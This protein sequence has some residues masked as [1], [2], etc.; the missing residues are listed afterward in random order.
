VVAA[1]VDT[2]VLIDILR[3]N[4]AA[5]NWLTQQPDRL[6]IV[7]VVWLEVIQ[8]ADNRRKQKEA[9]TLL[10]RFERVELIDSDYD[11]AIKQA[12]L[13]NL[14]HNVGGVDCLIASVN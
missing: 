14:S 9:L 6:G 4:P 5:Q 2:S 7:P 12:I 10:R 11:W 13:F 1:L 3:L 8:G